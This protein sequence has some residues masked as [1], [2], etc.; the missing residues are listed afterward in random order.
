MSGIDEARAEVDDHPD[1]DAI[2]IPAR[3]AFDLRAFTTGE[4]G[5][6]EPVDFGGTGADSA[7]RWPAALAQFHEVPSPPFRPFL[8]TVK[9]LPCHKSQA[10]R[11]EQAPI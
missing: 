2:D 7:C 11:I 8:S 3:A 6:F 9:Q 10:L 5:K 4:I 1:Y